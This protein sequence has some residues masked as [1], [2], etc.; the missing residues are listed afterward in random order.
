VYLALRP[1]DL[2]ALFRPARVLPFYARVDRVLSGFVEFPAVVGLICL[3]YTVGSFL[4][5]LLQ[6]WIILRAWNVGGIDVVAYCFPL[7]VLTNAVPLTVAGLGTREGAA[8]LLLR[9]YGIAQSVA[10]TSAF[11]MFFM[12]TAVPGII[13]ALITPFVKAK[14]IGTSAQGAEVTGTLD[15]RSEDERMAV[16]PVVVGPR[17]AGQ[18]Q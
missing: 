13:G 3:L 2:R 18:G 15:R 14:G 10:A 8:I 4:I 12:N 7:V 9:H 5:V 1:R 6:Y 11:L 17:P 16:Q